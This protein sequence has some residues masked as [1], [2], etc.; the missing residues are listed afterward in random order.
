MSKVYFSSLRDDWRT[1]KRLYHEL[2]IEFEFDFDPCPTEPNYDG[3]FIEWGSRN[4]V[5]PPYSHWQ[6][7]VKKG[8]E[9][10]K[11][12]KLVVFLLAARTDTKAF[13]D[14]ILPY[15][16]EIRFIRGRLRFDDSK[17]H[18]P[19]PSMVVIFKHD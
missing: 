4:F 8:Y 3:L 7:W 1:P 15:A 2:N 9:Q 14:Y 11:K 13:H 17:K 18:A 19:F 10:W 12:G 5:N 16:T 6:K